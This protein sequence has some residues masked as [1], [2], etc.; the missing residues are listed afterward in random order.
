MTLSP[1]LTESGIIFPLLSYWPGPHSTT[2]PNPLESGLFTIMPDD[3]LL[4]VYTLRTTIRFNK[5]SKRL[6]DIFNVDLL[7]L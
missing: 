3:V 2:T 7:Y 1:T 4:D 6:N 5:G